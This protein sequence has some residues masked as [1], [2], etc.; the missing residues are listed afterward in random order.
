MRHEFKTSQERVKG[1]ILVDTAKPKRFMSMQTL[2]LEEVGTKNVNSWYEKVDETESRALEKLQ[3]NH[4]YRSKI[5]NA[6]Q[7]SQ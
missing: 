4:L 7:S 3:S 6:Y 2:Y 1:P 5:V